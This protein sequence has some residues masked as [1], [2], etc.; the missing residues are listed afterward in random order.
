[1]NGEIFPLDWLQRWEEN[2][3]TKGQGRLQVNSG[4]PLNLVFMVFILGFTLCPPL[5]AL[6]SEFPN[7]RYH[8]P[9]RTAIHHEDKRPSSW[10]ARWHH[11]GSQ[12]AGWRYGLGLQR[13]SSPKSKAKQHTDL[14]KTSSRRNGKQIAKKHICSVELGV[15]L[16]NTQN[17]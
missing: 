1:M 14:R 4:F 5:K 9:L 17:Q 10:H 16:A 6:W 12:F 2:E 7:H 3:Y 15:S 11:I 13:H 8:R